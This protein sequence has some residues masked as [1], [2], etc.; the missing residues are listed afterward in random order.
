M[1]LTYSDLISIRNILTTYSL[2]KYSEGD[3]SGVSKIAYKLAQ[4]VSEEIAEME[5][6]NA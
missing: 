1:K 6:A 4:K 2:K 5:S 3:E